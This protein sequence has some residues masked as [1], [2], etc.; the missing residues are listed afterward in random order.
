MTNNVNDFKARL[1]Q[2]GITL[3]EPITP[4]QLQTPWFVRALQ[5][6]SGWLAALFLLG[7]I[8]MGV[9]FVAESPAASLGSGLVMIGAAYGLFRK[10]RSDVLEHL[11]L[12]VSLAGQLLI[13]WAAVAFWSESA[14]PFWSL[15]GWSL[16][17]LQ[18]VLAVVMPSLVHRTFSAFSASLALYMALAVNA[19]APVVSGIVMLALTMLW[20]NEFR[21]PGRIR[22]VHA[23]SYGLLIGLL[24]MQGVAHIGQSFAFWFDA[25]NTNVFAWSGPWLNAVLVALSLVLLLFYTLPHP[26]IHWGLYLSPIG[27]LLISFYAPGVGQGLMVLLLGFAM[28]HRLVMGL[29]VFSLLMGVGSYYYWLDATLLTKAL[30]LLILG[31]VLLA[32]RWA[33]RKWLASL[34]PTTKGV[35]DEE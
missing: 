33:L 31:G 13:A 26:K 18:S 15:L 24:V 20:L 35:A 2:A 7:F 34:K 29:G 1:T 21:W 4:A 19:M 10:A 23:W 30:T 16:L 11:A 14:Y 12:A 3:N 32:L 6:F 28:S 5:A 9:V 17:A 27:L 8:A 22:D 25:Q